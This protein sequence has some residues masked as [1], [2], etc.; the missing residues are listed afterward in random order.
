MRQEEVGEVKRAVE[1]VPHCS[2]SFAGSL[3][4]SADMVKDFGAQKADSWSVSYALFFMGPHTRAREPFFFFKSS[5]GTS[6]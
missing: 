1:G 5:D 3:G 2:Q 4:L 6:W